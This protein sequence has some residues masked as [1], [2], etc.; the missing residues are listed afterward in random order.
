MMLYFI[1]GPAEIEN[2]LPAYYAHG[3]KA[4]D[5]YRGTIVY[6]FF[7]SAFICYRIINYSMILWLTVYLIVYKIKGHFEFADIWRFFFKGGEVQVHQLQMFSISVVFFFLVAKTPVIKDIVNTHP[8]L[9]TL[10]AVV[11]SLFVYWFSII[12]MFASKR[13]IRFDDIK[14]GWRYNYGTENK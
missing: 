9:L 6:L 5:A 3:Y 4:L 8:W 14:Y 2:A 13:T 11:V 12:A 7:I 10:F 1:A